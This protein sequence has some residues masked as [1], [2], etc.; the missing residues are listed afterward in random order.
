MVGDAS[1][2]YPSHC[3]HGNPIYYP[4]CPGCVIEK[5]HLRDQRYENYIRNKHCN[6][7]NFWGF[8]RNMFEEEDYT[9]DLKDVEVVNSKFPREFTP[10]KK[11]DSFEELRKEYFKLCRVCHPDKPTGNTALFQRLQNLYERLVQRFI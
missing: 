5:E 1:D 7:H 9:E 10:L 3:K 11:S 2:I 8:F 4:F 6:D